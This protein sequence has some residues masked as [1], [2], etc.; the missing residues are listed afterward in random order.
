MW[1]NVNV[2]PTANVKVRKALQMVYDYQSGLNAVWGGKGNTIKGIL[3]ST[4]SC[5]P[6]LPGYSRTSPRPRRCWPRRDHEL[7]M[8]YQ[9]ALNQFTQEATLFQSNLK[10]IGVTL[11]LVPIKFSDWLTSLSSTQ[12]SR[13]D[14]DG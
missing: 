7:T 4:M 1:M 12:H 8:R 5:Q 11:K 14:A 9:P 10:S 13:A 3:P 2:G 6:T